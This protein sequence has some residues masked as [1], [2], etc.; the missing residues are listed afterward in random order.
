MSFDDAKKLEG[1]EIE[2]PIFP[3]CYKNE[4][5]FISK[6]LKIR[7]YNLLCE[8]DPWIYRETTSV[9]LQV[10]K[11]YVIEYWNKY[12]F[13][14]DFQ[15]FQSRKYIHVESKDEEVLPTNLNTTLY[16]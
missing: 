12:N 13:W 3:I 2:S 16:E 1:I 4:T 10:K 9:I 5:R 14:K 6:L 15:R 8:A 11:F 7:E